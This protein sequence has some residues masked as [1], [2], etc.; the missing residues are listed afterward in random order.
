[1]E[2]KLYAAQLQTINWALDIIFDQETGVLGAERHH[3]L[4]CEI[5]APCYV[6]VTLCR[7]V[8]GSIHQFDFYVATDDSK[9]FDTYDWKTA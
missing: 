8:W 3:L 2:I 7:E 1:M 4:K 6:K 9:K 5:L